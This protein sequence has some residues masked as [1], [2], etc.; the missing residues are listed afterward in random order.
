MK[1]VN[2][3]VELREQVNAWRNAGETIAFVPTM[4][5][6]H[7]GHLRLIDVAREHGSRVVAS[8]F[9]NP[10][11]FVPGTDFEDYPRTLE[12]DFQKLE[13]QGADLLFSPNVN[14]IYGDDGKSI[15][16]VEVKEVS[17]M[18]C[19]YYR[20][21]HFFGVTTVVAKL[22]NLVQPQVAVFGEK[23]FQQ[24]YIIRQMVKDLGFPVEIVGVPTMREEDGLAMSSRNQY[25]SD[26]ERVIAG[27]IYETMLEVK[28][29]VEAKDLSFN[30]IETH[31]TQRLQSAGFRPEYLSIR[32]SSDLK[33]GQPDAD[34]LRVFVAAWLGEARLIDNL[35]IR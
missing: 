15:T 1:Q 2:T 29:K 22:F 21:G 11:Q 3:I 30:L 31:A 34:H 26:D 27:Q 32:Q 12:S 10:L 6:L 28:A 14:E 13:N 19:G 18:M 8:I 16:R 33:P 24:L 35:E 17:D 7:A 5:N 23:D 20:P 9:V 4:G 25:L